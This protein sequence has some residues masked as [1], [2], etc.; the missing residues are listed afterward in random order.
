M[1]NTRP[2]KTLRWRII[3]ADIR[4]Y[5]PVQPSWKIKRT[6]ETK[7]KPKKISWSIKYTASL[8]STKCEEAKSDLPNERRGEKN[9]T[10]HKAVNTSVNKITR[11]SCSNL[12]HH[13]TVL[14]RSLQMKFIFDSFICQN[15]QGKW[16]WHGFHLQKTRPLPGDKP[17]V[18]RK[19]TNPEAIENKNCRKWQNNEKIP[20]YRPSQIGRKRIV[21]LKIEV[22]NRFFHYCETLG[23]TP[24]QEFH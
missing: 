22:Y 19:K 3:W 13:R 21:E 6:D 7:Q 2:A 16:H 17:P 18:D 10:N 12:Q 14:T 23:S 4:S 9:P 20:E 24:L 5:R 1:C 11:T 15:G 8:N